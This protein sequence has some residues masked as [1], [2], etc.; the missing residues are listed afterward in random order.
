VR[1]GWTV[2]AWHGH[3]LLPQ[4]PIGPPYFAVGVQNVGGYADL[5]DC[6]PGSGVTGSRQSATI[7]CT[8]SIALKNVR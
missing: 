5:S 1:T 6:A 3:L 2:R 8:T 7:S 4:S